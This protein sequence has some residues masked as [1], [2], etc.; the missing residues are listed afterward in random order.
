M[1][2]RS[3]LCTP[4]TGADYWGRSPGLREPVYASSI[5]EAPGE[6][7]CVLATRRA[8]PEKEQEYIQEKKF[9]F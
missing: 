1:V 6:G 2:R 3:V 7:N 8:N 4:G 9:L 5:S